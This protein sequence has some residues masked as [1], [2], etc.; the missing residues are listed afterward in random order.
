MYVIV[1]IKSPAKLHYFIKLCKRLHFFLLF[2]LLFLF[3]LYVLQ[4]NFKS[5]SCLFEKK[6]VILWAILCVA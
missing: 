5:M 4:H 3:F 1:H 2:F 6:T